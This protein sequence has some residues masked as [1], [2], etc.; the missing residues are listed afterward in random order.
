M[1]LYMYMA[2]ACTTPTN[3]DNKN[4]QTIIIRLV[5]TDPLPIYILKNYI[6][7]YLALMF[8]PMMGHSAIF[9]HLLLAGMKRVGA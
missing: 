4:Q 3:Y 8:H 7:Y 2:H 6:N 1:Y 5:I 9:K